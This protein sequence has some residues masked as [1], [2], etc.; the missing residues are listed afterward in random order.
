MNLSRAK[1]IVDCLETIVSGKACVIPSNEEICAAA[2]FLS[3]CAG[4]DASGRAWLDKRL[5][6]LPLVIDGALTAELRSLGNT[7]AVRSEAVPDFLR[8]ISY[9][10]NQIPVKERA[11]SLLFAAV[12]F[13]Y[14]VLCLRIDDFFIPAK[15]GSGMHL[16]GPPV[17]VMFGAT[18]C[19]VVV[20]LAV[21]V[22]HY[23]RRD[24]ERH[25]E[26]ISKFFRTA[27][28]GLFLAAIALDLFL[29]F[30]K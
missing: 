8:N 13:A 4:L 30:S 26:A 5:N 1:N 10:P 29:K 3:D 15:R 9:V 25:Y 2:R 17:W 21:V 12:L 28:W 20:L 7:V 11:S 14:S 23:D 19:A 22:N 16:H 24:N 27:G 6:A 18:L